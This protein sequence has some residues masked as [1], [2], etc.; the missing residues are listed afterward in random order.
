MV[1]DSISKADNISKARKTVLA[2]MDAMNTL[3][4]PK[5]M[6]LHTE[7]YR[8][9]MLPLSLKVPVMDNAGYEAYFKK[10]LPLFHT[11]ECFIN[12]LIE[13]YK[14]KK[15]VVYARDRA[16]TDLGEYRCEY[17]LT[18]FLTDDG[19][20]LKRMHE[21]VDPSI[22]V[23]WVTKLRKLLAENEAQKEQAASML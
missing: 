21:W 4:L 20:K 10:D 17:M 16:D 3:D 15:I 14:Q 9:Q 11:Y 5:I 23:P 12:D 1:S 8:H 22:A 18:F 19:T 6:S 7:D 13:D 2:Y